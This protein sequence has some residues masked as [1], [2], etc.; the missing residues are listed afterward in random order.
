MNR[1]P[2]DIVHLRVTLKVKPIVLDCGR[3]AA[4]QIVFV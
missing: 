1:P 4:A 2:L 3:G